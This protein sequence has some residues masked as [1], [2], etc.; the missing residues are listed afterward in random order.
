MFNY[1]KG[2]SSNN[3]TFTM[4]KSKPVA[5]TSLLNEIKTK[6]W[7]LQEMRSYVV[8][9]LAVF[10]TF[11]SIDGYGLLV[12]LYTGEWETVTLSMIWLLVIRSTVKTA[13]TLLFPKLFPVRK[14]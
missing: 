8:T 6:H 11:I 10:L 5:K 1:T 12:S 14:P 7:W 4:T 13:L 2:T 3:F 9:V